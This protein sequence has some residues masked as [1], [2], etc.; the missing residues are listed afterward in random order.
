MKTASLLILLLFIISTPAWAV[1]PS[2][3]SPGGSLPLQGQ[4]VQGADGSWG[5]ISGSCFFGTPLI[6]SSA[7]ST[8]LVKS[9]NIIPCRD[10][11]VVAAGYV[12]AFQDGSLNASGS[13]DY[14]TYW[15]CPT[16]TP[17]TQDYALDWSKTISFIL[18]G[19]TGLGFVLA[20]SFRW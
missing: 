1:S 18:G 6:R 17:A 8:T 19:L 16:T 7:L 13:C 14:P 4:Y 11:L 3:Y 15:A 12:T 5:Q 20:S 10:G 2:V 9:W